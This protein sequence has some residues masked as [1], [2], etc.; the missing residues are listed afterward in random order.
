M[1]PKFRGNSDD[2]LDDEDSSHARS[3]STRPKKEI[4]ARALDL[5]P[6]EANA[7]VAEVF[8]NQ[9]R[10]KLDLDQSDLLCN[11][12]RAGVV[13]KSKENTRERT[14][15]AV[16]DRV[17]VS[18]SGESNGV[19]EGVCVRKNCLSRP[20]PGRDGTKIQHVL[21][22]NIDVLV[23]VASI[24][25]PVF[26]T[27]LIDRFLVAAEAEGIES[28]ICMTKSDL[29][30]SMARRPWDIYQ[31]LG[32][33]VFEVSSKRSLG[34]SSL[35]EQIKEKTAVFCGQS[36]VGKTSLLR[37][38]L[39]FN[40][41]R[42]AEVNPQTGK[43]RHTTT[44]AILLEGPSAS[45]WIDTP[46]V[47]EFGLSQNS[48]QTLAS[49]FREFRDLHCPQEGCLHLNEPGCC[50]KSLERYPSYLRILNSLLAGEN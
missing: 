34:L 24:Q 4:I 48:P 15:V 12:R 25:E 46:G 43:G 8:P 33:R 23:I 18:T 20:A 6:S 17:L 36:G 1:S 41:G 28:Y 31:K 13:S 27:G 16:G 40:V 50:A 42:V 38:L 32:Y 39:G 47:K 29:L 49:C 5:P 10:I 2:W 11:Y 3:L 44:G 35:L 22:V 30:D 7:I 37:G 9:C 21:A 45:R 14:P 26:T 19:I